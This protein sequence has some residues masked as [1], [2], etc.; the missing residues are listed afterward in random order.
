M[1]ILWVVNGIMP[2]MAEKMGVQVTAGGSWLNEPLDILSRR[3]ELEFHVVTMWHKKQYVHK[4]IDNVYYYVLPGNYIN[5]CWK[6]IGKYGK[7]CKKIVEEVKPD[8][9][10]I[11][12]GEFAF[13]L[14]FLPYIKCPSLLTVQGFMSVINKKYYYG[15]IKIPSLFGC[16]LPWNFA[17][18]F[19]MK[20]R[21]YENHLRGISEVKQVR[22]VD[23]I[24]GNTS[25]DYTQSRLMNPNSVY[26]NLDYAIRREFFA[27]KWNIGKVKRHSLLFVN[28]GVPLK[29]FHSLLDAAKLLEKKYPDLTIKVAGTNTTASRYVNGYAKY[30]K[31]KINKLELSGKIEFLG[32]L[33]GERM[34]EEMEKIHTF[35][36]ASCIE[37]GPNVL[38][39]AMLV[40]VPCVSSFVG[41]AMD[42]AKGEEEALFYRFDEPELLAYHIDRIW[43]D[44]ELAVRLSGNAAERARKRRDFEEVSEGLREIY[45]KTAATNIASNRE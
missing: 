27:R 33:S 24:I 38:L 1:K 36:L 30:L 25:W 15:G 21:H 5:E 41:G 4:K 18:Y 19:P 32:S 26:Y 22:F 9:F 2:R 43:S 42:Y 6:P 44:D 12:G 13:G 39:E 29:G 20:I 23:G 11:F 37:N 45:N 17:T 31:K 8:I 14:G 34:A 16:L 35:T 7:L 40:G 10:H 28:I 3:E